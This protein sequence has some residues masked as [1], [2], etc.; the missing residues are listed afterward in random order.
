MF[1]VIE[2]NRR[3]K[4]ADEMMKKE[5]L[6]GLLMVGNGAVGTNSY[7]CFRYLTDNRVYY[8]LLTAVFAPDKEPVAIATSFISQLEFINNSFIKDCRIFSDA[9]EGICAIFE[10]MELNRKGRNLS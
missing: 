9:V 3:F 6:S 10:E 5:G 7:G 8:Y 2:R 4:A 1:S